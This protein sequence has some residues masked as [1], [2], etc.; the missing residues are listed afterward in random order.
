MT[1]KYEQRFLID[2]AF[3][4]AHGFPARSVVAQELSS[5]VEDQDLGFDWDP[6][7]DSFRKKGVPAPVWANLRKRLADRVASAAQPKPDVL[8]ENVSLLA[9]HVGLNADERAI[10]EL[11]VRA[12]R[13]GP[14]KS[15]CNSLVDDARI[16]VLDT[17]TQ[18]S[19]LPAASVRRAL[20]PAGRLVVS[21][22]LQFDKPPLSGIG[23]FPSDRLLV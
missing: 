19:G 7:I 23:L 16:P 4:V 3:R 8:A 18:L 11:A 20:A 6:E 15:L 9:D 12:G 10:F 2:L 13:S 14:V 21:G 22:L 17:V 1:N 5:W